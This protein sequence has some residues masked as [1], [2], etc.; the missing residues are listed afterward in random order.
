MWRRRGRSELQMYVFEGFGVPRI[1]NGNNA[2]GTG[3]TGPTSH[4][5]RAI[6]E[7]DPFQKDS[8]D[9][10]RDERLAK[11]SVGRRKWQHRPPWWSTV[12]VRCRFVFS[13]PRGGTRT[14]TTTTM[15]MFNVLYLI[16]D[17][18]I[19]DSQKNKISKN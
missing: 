16:Y 2:A 8:R 4:Q 13:L 15:M 19:N 7:I 18:M 10:D 9:S 11:I 17:S 6:A 3:L 12:G 5:S 1:G 14:T